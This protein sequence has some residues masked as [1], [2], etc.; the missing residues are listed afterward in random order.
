MDVLQQG[1]VV[2]RKVPLVLSTMVIKKLVRNL[3]VQVIIV[4]VYL[5]K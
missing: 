4:G 2:F 5:L 1:K 3:L